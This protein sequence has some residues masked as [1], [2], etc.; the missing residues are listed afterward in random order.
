MRIAPTNLKISPLTNIKQRGK[1]SNQ[2]IFEIGKR[3]GIADAVKLG[4]VYA[5]S[6]STMSAT[7]GGGLLFVMLSYAY[8]F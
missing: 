4:I 6:N 5:P 1:G 3:L 8:S 2:P 7:A